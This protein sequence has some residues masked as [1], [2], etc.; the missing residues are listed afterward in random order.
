MFALTGSIPPFAS[1]DFKELQAPHRLGDRKPMSK[2]E[3]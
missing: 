3:L 2:R 1:G